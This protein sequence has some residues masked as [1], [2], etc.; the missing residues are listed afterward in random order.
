M[1]ETSGALADEL[2]HVRQLRVKDADV[3]GQPVGRQQAD[4]FDE[5]RLEAEIN[6]FRLQQ[7]ADALD[8]RHSG[9]GLEIFTDR[10][11]PFK[12]RVGH[13]PANTAVLP[14]KA[15]YPFRFLDVLAGVAFALHK[16][17]LLHLNL[18]AGLPIFFQQVPPVQQGD[19][20]QPAVPQV[21]RVPEMH[22]GVDDRETHH[23]VFSFRGVAL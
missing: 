21:I 12:R 18:P 9:Q 23:G 6:G 1:K 2:D 19:I 10:R 7:A 15:G 17:H 22:V 14:G 16:D 13:D 4:A 20:V 5:S 11:A 3:E 8:Q